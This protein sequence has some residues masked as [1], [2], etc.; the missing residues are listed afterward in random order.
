[1]KK[2]TGAL[3]T[4]WNKLRV[5]PL[6]ESPAEKQSLGAPSADAVPQMESGAPAGGNGSAPA[7]GP[8]HPPSLLQGMI[9][10]AGT[11]QNLLNSAM[12]FVMGTPLQI[13]PSIAA[14]TVIKEISL[15][16]SKWQNPVARLFYQL[17]KNRSPAIDIKVEVTGAV[18]DVG[19]LAT[20]IVY[21]PPAN[22]EKYSDLELQQHYLT[23]YATNENNTVVTTLT[24]RRTSHFAR[25]DEYDREPESQYPKLLVF[26]AVPIYNTSGA[27][28][29]R[30]RIRVGDRLHPSSM[31]TM[32][33]LP[34]VR[35]LTNSG[36]GT[37]LSIPLEY[38]DLKIVVD[39]ASFISANDRRHL[40]PDIN[41]YLI[42]GPSVNKSIRPRIGALQYSF[43]NTGSKTDFNTL[44]GAMTLDESTG[45]WAVEIDVV[46]DYTNKLMSFEAVEGTILDIHKFVGVTQFGTTSQTRNFWWVRTTRGTFLANQPFTGARNDTSVHQFTGM[47]GLL[48]VLMS[49]EDPPTPIGES[50]CLFQKFSSS[51]TSG[52]YAGEN[53]L[54]FAGS[55]DQVF[56]QELGI[57]HD[58]AV[59][60]LTD[61]TTDSTV[62]YLR[63]SGTFKS[64]SIRAAP[65]I[66]SNFTLSNCYISHITREF[67]GKLPD[68]DLSNFSSR[69]ASQGTPQKIIRCRTDLA[70]P[71]AERQGNLISTGMQIHAQQEMLTQQLDQ[72]AWQNELN[73][74]FNAWNAQQNRQHSEFLQTRD[75][76]F[77]AQMRGLR[78]GNLDGRDIPAG[79]QLSVLPPAY[80]KHDP[81]SSSEPKEGNSSSA[82]PKE[83]NSSLAKPK[84]G[85][86]P[87]QPF[88]PETGS[89]DDYS[90]STAASESTSGEEVPS[91][92]DPPIYSEQSQAI[93][94]QMGHK[95]GEGL[96]KQSQGI[97]SPIQPDYS[98]LAGGKRYPVLGS[99]P[100]PVNPSGT[101]LKS[102]NAKVPPPATLAGRT[103]GKIAAKTA[104]KTALKAASKAHPALIA[105]EVAHEVISSSPTSLGQMAPVQPMQP[106][107][108]LDGR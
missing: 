93:M 83:G 105:A 77:K 72:Q 25:T 51:I 53:S 27:D 58:E 40:G 14:W 45:G 11:A 76:H 29:P 44:Y 2:A 63:W 1:M 86:Y 3:P 20:C 13:D 75:Q 68:T 26:V 100:T 4:V 42:T 99:D 73:R 56:A 23:L 55:L 64:W 61:R 80:S 24:D 39:G 106:T 28:T 30:I 52:N 7:I 37:R 49:A 103:S 32:P 34:L 108:S 48:P 87:L 15:H 6:P 21:G 74:E 46:F 90:L 12:E 70:E 10:L 79:T 22:G 69:V 16:E 50:R 91:T 82:K 62:C 89:Y 104:S 47:S 98:D 85:N 18:F 78:L 67:S 5:T 88:V 36:T 35:S 17:H 33:N 92:S 107:V 19:K 81:F 96:G 60:A 66:A 57:A 95:E 38:Q 97:T 84:E 9:T 71:P 54:P 102:A 65:Y 41:G 94:K 31:F 8:V 43:V 101:G 59:V